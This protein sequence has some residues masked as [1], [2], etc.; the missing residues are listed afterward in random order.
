MLGAQQEDR[1]LVTSDGGLRAVE[2]GTTSAGDA[3]KG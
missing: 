3:L 1:D 2:A